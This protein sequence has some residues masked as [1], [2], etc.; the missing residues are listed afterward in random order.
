[1]L[2]GAKAEQMHLRQ[3]TC[4]ARHAIPMFPIGFNQS[5]K[6]LSPP[7]GSPC[8]L[9]TVMV[10]GVSCLALVM[11]FLA[12]VLMDLMRLRLGRLMLIVSCMVCLSCVM[13]NSTRG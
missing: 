12:K 9:V 1:M 2:S 8:H 7:L 6:G 4:D 3:S 11:V 10:M 13:I 5:E